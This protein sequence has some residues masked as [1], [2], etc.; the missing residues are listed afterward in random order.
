MKFTL[1]QVHVFTASDIVTINVVLN[2]LF[3]GFVP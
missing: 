2:P 3:L 1:E